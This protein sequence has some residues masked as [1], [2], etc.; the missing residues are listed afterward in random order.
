[1]SISQ[2]KV[3]E[4]RSADAPRL[5][6]HQ[7]DPALFT[8]DRLDELCREAD[9]HGTLKVQ[10]ADPGRQRYGND[11]VYTRPSYPILEDA[12]RRPIQYRISDV[13]VFGGPDYRAC[14]DHIFEVAG[15]DPALGR[16]LPE[17]VVRV[18]SPGAVVAL[19]GD[20]DLKLV[21]TLAGETIWWVRPPSEMSV[22]EHERLL[23][24]NF[25]LQ[26]KE[27]EDRPLPIPP[28]HGCF[29]PSRWAHWL[30]HP[31]DVPVVSFEIGYWSY[32]SINARKVYDVNWMLRRLGLKPE[33][34]G[35]GKDDLK[36]RV[37]DG[38]STV[39]RKGVQYRGI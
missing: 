16:F 27:A 19:H 4:N 25:F 7:L 35:A 24:G 1:M 2:E 6:E 38:I 3:N 11:P 14:L 13:D 37:F 9:R 5:F 23:R 12:M 21:S 36:R 8:S 17:T 18:F 29:V 31:V 26:W 20:P 15:T 22:E 33:V 10:F 34:P 28:G 39:T 30:T 32:E